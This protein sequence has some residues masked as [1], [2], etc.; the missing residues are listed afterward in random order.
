MTK[1]L[2]GKV[3][4]I[5][6]GASGIGERTAEIFV[7]QGAQVV[8]AGRSADKGLALADKLGENV[9][10]IQTDVSQEKQVK[11]MIELAVDRFGRLD[12]LF[13]NAGSTGPYGLIE[14][15]DY[16]EVEAI[17]SVLFGGVSLGMKY[18]API[19]KE[20]RSG[21]ILNTASVAGIR[22]GYGPTIYSAVKAAVIH[23]T[24]CVAMELAEYG[25]RVNSISPGGIATPIFGKSLGLDQA[26]AD[27][28]MDSVIVTLDKSLPLKRSGLA[29]DIAYGA[30]YLASDEGSFVTGHDL[31]IDSGMTVGRKPQ[32]QAQSYGPL[33]EEAV[34]NAAEE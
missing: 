25:I 30:L 20:Q 15:M 22:V 28:I 8:V 5:T 32:Q 4:V 19:M 3:A 23:L 26:A 12:C 13:N 2:A 14:D 33:V 21:C 1:R 18:A 24:K 31:V 11:A 16:A 17:M 10:F 9:V 27:S 29:E 34:R 6:G 7:E